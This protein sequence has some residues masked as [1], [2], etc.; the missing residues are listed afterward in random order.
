[1]SHQLVNS[2]PDK[3][4]RLNRS[5]Q[6]SSILLIRL[7]FSRR[8]DPLGCTQLS[9]NRAVFSL[10]QLSR[11]NLAVETSADWTS[12]RCCVDPLRPPP[13]PEKVG[14]G[15]KMS[16]NPTN[17]A[18][19]REQIRRGHYSIGG[20][21]ALCPI[22]KSRERGSFVALFGGDFRPEGLGY[23]PVS[24]C[25]ATKRIIVESGSDGCFG[26]GF[27]NGEQRIRTECNPRI[28]LHRGCSR[29]CV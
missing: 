7:R 13:L 14:T 15:T 18:V 9:L 29:N 23:P 27:Y 12:G 20:V 11:T 2:T 6:H 25:Y 10:N 3:R 4:R 5:M 28:A 16:G 19:R 21:N 26:P 24:R 22:L 8:P 17:Q 1:M